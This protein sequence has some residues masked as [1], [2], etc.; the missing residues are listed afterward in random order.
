MYKT[1]TITAENQWTTPIELIGDF[2]YSAQG[3]FSAKVTLQRSLDNIETWEDVDF[4]ISPFSYIGTEPYSPFK[5]SGAHIFYRLGVKTGD[6]VS[7]TIN[8]KLGIR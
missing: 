4:N 1:K 2:N 8:V 5:V 6:F 7:G 3:T